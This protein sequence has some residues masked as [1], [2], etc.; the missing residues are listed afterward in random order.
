MGATSFEDI[1]CKDDN[2]DE[3][4]RQVMQVLPIVDSYSILTGK[5]TGI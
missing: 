5:T 2:F 1:T 3:W 4:F